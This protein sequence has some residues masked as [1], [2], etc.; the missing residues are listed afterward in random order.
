M[1]C[2]DRHNLE[3][4]IIKGGVAGKCPKCEQRTMDGEAIGEFQC[5]YSEVLCEWCGDSPCDESC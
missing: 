3:E 5:G 1:P 2:A 4:R